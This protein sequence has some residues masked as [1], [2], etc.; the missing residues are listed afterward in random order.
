MAESW[1][2]SVRQLLFV[3]MAK[4]D[5][6]T[7]QKKKKKVKLLVTQHALWLESKQ[8]CTL[9]FTVILCVVFVCVFVLS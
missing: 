1:K 4:F 2:E 3:R 8:S 7:H 5:A 6:P 9:D